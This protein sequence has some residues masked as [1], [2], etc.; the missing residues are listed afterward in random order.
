MDKERGLTVVLWVV[1]L[2]G[3]FFL[4]RGLT[5]KA[6][7]D[8]SASDQCI[9]DNLCSSGMVCCYGTCY[10]PEVCSQIK[11]SINEEPKMQIGYLFDIG[12]GLLVLLAI[13]I[14]FYAF[15]NRK[16]EKREVSKVKRLK[17]K[18]K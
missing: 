18:K 6:V 13:L 2:F 1:V 8:L 4:A 10:T 7:L 12:L 17:R 9:S 5:G 11:N 3:I 14:A 16:G 15:H